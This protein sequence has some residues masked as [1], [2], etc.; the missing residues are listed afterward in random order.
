LR[1]GKGGLVS[2]DESNIEVAL[3]NPHLPENRRLLSRNECGAMGVA[4][5]A[6]C[7]ALNAVSHPARTRLAGGSAIGPLSLERDQS[8][9]LTSLAINAPTGDE[10][11]STLSAAKKRPKSGNDILASILA[12]ALLEDATT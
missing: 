12:P 8:L 9:Y 3:R 6:R 10:G 1:L 2:C 7:G 11:A 4:F 5:Y